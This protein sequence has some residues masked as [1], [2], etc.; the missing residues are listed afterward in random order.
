M[1]LTK[2][3]GIKVNIDKKRWLIDPIV[4]IS[5]P[6]FINKI[7]IKIKVISKIKKKLKSSSKKFKA[8]IKVDKN[9]INKKRIVIL[10][11]S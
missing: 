11:T 3:P 5:P 2:I 7:G 9:K 4:C 1:R 8:N 10:F 6:K